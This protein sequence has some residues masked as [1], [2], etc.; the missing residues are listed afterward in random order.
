MIRTVAPLVMSSWASVNWVES[1]PW[2]FCTE[3][4]DEVRPAVVS[5]LVRYGASNSVYRAEETVSGR[6]TPMLPLPLAASG[7]SDAI[8][9]KS[10]VKDDVEMLGTLPE[11]PPLEAELLEEG[12]LLPPPPLLQ[13]ARGTPAV[14]AS[15]DVQLIL[16]IK[17]KGSP[18]VSAGTADGR[19]A[20]MR[21]SVQETAAASAFD[22]NLKPVRING[23]LT[24]PSRH[25]NSVNKTVR[26]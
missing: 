2:A 16:V 3:N 7:F 5:A 20:S 15:A 21:S 18:Q 22:G 26:R 23:A 25:K 8:A 24:S 14:T 13:A 1:L 11:P 19:C 12:E 6:I 17:F 4:C 10:R 9:E